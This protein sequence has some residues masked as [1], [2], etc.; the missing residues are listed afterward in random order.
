MH[1]HEMVRSNQTLDV[2]KQGPEVSNDRLNM[3]KWK[4]LKSQ[5]RLQGFWKTV[6]FCFF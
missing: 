3:V 6:L 2:L 5:G 4:K 1:A